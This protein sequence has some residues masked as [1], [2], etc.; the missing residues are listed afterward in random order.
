MDIYSKK[1]NILQCRALKILGGHIGDMTPGTK[2]GGLCRL[3]SSAPC[4]AGMFCSLAAGPGMS[5]PCTSLRRKGCRLY[6]ATAAPSLASYR[7]PHSVSLK[8]GKQKLQPSLYVLFPRRAIPAKRLIRFMRNGLPPG[9]LRSGQNMPFLPFLCPGTTWK[10]GG[11]LP[12]RPQRAPRLFPSHRKT[13]P[14]LCLPPH[15]GNPRGMT[16]AT[17]FP[18]CLI[19]KKPSRPGAFLTSFP[20]GKQAS[21]R[22]RKAHGHNRAPP[23]KGFVMRTS[24]RPAHRRK[25]RFSPPACIPPAHGPSGC[26]R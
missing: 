9:K 24:G 22:R 12:R 6:P 10:K 20:P 2:K 23:A 3:F 17:S 15:Q 11:R 25:H 18:V 26:R 5:F 19:G 14:F 13:A 7:A 16:A 21:F 1:Q 8:S 4:H